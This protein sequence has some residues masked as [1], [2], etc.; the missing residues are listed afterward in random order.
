MLVPIRMG[1]KMADGKE[2]KH[3]SLSF[4][5]KVRIYLSKIS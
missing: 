2:Q 4:A 1:N 3:V 5:E